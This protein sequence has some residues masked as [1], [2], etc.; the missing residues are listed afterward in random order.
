MDKKTKEIMIIKNNFRKE[1]YTFVSNDNIV[2]NT[3]ITNL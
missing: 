1:D 2:N 3:K